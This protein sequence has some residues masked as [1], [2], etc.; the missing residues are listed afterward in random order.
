MTD[1]LRAWFREELTDMEEF[2]DTEE[3]PDISRV[4]HKSAVRRWEEELLSNPQMQR[5][6]QHRQER[7]QSL[8]RVI[9]VI[10]CL[11]FIGVMLYMIAHMPHFGIANP[12]ADEV[13]RRYIE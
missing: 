3:K 10:S 8:Y 9:A 12:R 7:Y 13:A 5:E 11:L 1:R 4:E 2:L 6:I